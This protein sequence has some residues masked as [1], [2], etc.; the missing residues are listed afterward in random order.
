[1]SGRKRMTLCISV[2]SVVKKK[3]TTENTE[4]HGEKL[5]KRKMKDN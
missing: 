2:L 4:E 1:M 5:E 3:L